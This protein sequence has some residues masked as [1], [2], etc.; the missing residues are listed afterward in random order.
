[1]REIMKA[2]GTP[3][4][5]PAIVERELAKTTMEDLEA[6]CALNCSAGAHSSQMQSCEESQKQQE[7]VK[8]SDT[9]IT[10]I[11]TRRPVVIHEFGGME[12][13]L[14]DNLVRFIRTKEVIYEERNKIK[15]FKQ[16]AGEYEILP[17]RNVLVKTGS[18]SKKSVVKY[19]DGNAREVVLKGCEEAIIRR[20]HE[21]I[22][23][24]GINATVAEIR[25]NYDWSHIRLDVA[26]VLSTCENCRRNDAI[27]T[28]STELRPVAV[29]H[30]ILTQ[31]GIDLL[32]FPTSKKGNKYLIVCRDYLSKWVIVEPIA[33]KT[34]DAIVQFLRDKV[35]CVHG[36]F[37]VTVQSLRQI[38]F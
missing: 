38:N 3:H 19:S 28:G 10:A 16:K 17:E 1:M 18:R 35:I 27:P 29:P 22:L 23:H 15:W 21:S 6:F 5:L 14:Y 32:Q 25:Q 26:H 31:W 30:T 4:D 20:V 2:S 36:Y 11:A 34:A 33:N 37:K 7:A 13:E 9:E 8:V 24:K 12:P